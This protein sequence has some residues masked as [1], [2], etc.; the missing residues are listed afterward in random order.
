MDIDDFM[1]H[2][3]LDVQRLPLQWTR[4]GLDRDFGELVRHK[5]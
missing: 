3:L 5:K 1:P 2:G 4:I